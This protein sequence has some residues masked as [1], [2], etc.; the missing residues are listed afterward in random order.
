MTETA[1][2]PV[3][4]NPRT[5]VLALIGAG[6]I[7]RLLLAASIGLG[8][9]ES[10]AVAVARQYSLSYFDHP[11]LHFWL[12]GFAAKFWHSEAGLVVR[13]PFVLCFAGTTWLLF[14]LTTRFFGEQAGAVAALLLNIS[15][16]FSLSTGGWVLP[17][18][19][20]MLL[21][22]ASTT[23]FADLLFD[24]TVPPESREIGRWLL[25]GLLAGLAMLAKYHG[26]FVLGGVFLFPLSSRPQQR[27]QSTPGPYVAGAVALFCFLPVVIWN[28]DHGWVSFAFQGARATGSGGIHPGAMLTNI[29]GQAG[30]VLP[31]IWIP[32]VVTLVSSARHGPKDAARW[33]LLCIGIG[34]IAAFTL[35]ALR[36]S[37]GLP[38]WQ[39]PG[40]LFLFPALGAAA[41]A[42][43]GRGGTGTRRW[44]WASATTFV[45]LVSVLASHAATGW[46]KRVIPSAFAKGDPTADLVDWSSL[47]PALIGRGLLP[48]DGFV[49]APSWIQAGKASIG[50]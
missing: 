16:V 13:F 22:M 46:M 21:M 3:F 10:Y 48:V 2:T 5:F 6:I 19:P 45:L 32:L 11:P 24:E 42:R 23:V 49:A 39:A 29:A 8:V 18:G 14:R 37:V 7:A 38:H 34:P 12:A 15:A 26:I 35:I 4:K 50:L 47:R 44:L 41:A 30:W 17:D 43:I 40:Y 28:S 36:G 1:L 25:G 27:W 9:D 20:L 31:W 33:F